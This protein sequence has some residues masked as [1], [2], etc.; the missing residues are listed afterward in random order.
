M[1]LKDDPRIGVVIKARQLSHL[2]GR[3]NDKAKD[4]YMPLTIPILEELL[5]RCITNAHKGYMEH[6][7]VLSLKH[8]DPKLYAPCSSSAFYREFSSHLQAQLKM[9]DNIIV[10]TFYIYAR[11][12]AEGA[13]YELKFEIHWNLK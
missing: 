4:V 2:L 12:T 1:S 6:S 10:E 7:G 8:I 13:S 9:F 3:A 11:H 5:D